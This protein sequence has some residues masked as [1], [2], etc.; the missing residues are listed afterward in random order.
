[1]GLVFGKMIPY[2]FIG[3]FDVVA[4][5]S[6]GY[7]LFNVPL[8]GSFVEF[9]LMAIL[10]LIGTSGLGIFISAATRVQVFLFSLQW[11]QPIFHLSSFLDLYF[12]LIICLLW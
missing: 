4:T 6:V 1:M 3:L 10:F 11:L 2:L 9:Y 5:L 8:K 12:Q 7:F